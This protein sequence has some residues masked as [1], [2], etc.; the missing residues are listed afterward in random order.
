MARSANGWWRRGGGW[1]GRIDVLFANA[2]IA[3]SAPL[4]QATE[5]LFD[6]TFNLNVKSLFFPRMAKF[7]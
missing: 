4:E 6:E 5:A 7:P 1:G 3:K 2:G